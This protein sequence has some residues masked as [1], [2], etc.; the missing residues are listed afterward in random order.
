MRR[1]MAQ[2][3]RAPGPGIV[4]RFFPRSEPAG[5]HGVA[6]RACTAALYCRPFRAASACMPG[7]TPARHMDIT[8]PVT[9]ARG[10]RP[11]PVA[12][13]VAPPGQGSS[14]PFIARYRKEVTG[15]LDGTQ[16][17]Q[18]EER[19]RYLRELEER[20][21]AILSSIEEQGKLTPE[22]KREILAAETK[23]RLED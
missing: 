12:A 13:A 11:P 18:L 4:N 23:T 3:L 6:A 1:I 9:R 7:S 21:G 22:L 10:G 15:S 8:A 17:R 2:P 20:R 5:G 16:L 14:V 19:L